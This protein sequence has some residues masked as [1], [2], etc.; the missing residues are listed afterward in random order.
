[1]TA[2]P[3]LILLLGALASLGLA[4][5]GAKEIF[6]GLYDPILRAVGA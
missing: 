5:Y 3:K 4:V 6:A 2:R 1:M